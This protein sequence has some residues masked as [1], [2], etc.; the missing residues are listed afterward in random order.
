VSLY[1]A[2]DTATSIASVAVGDA[3][4]AVAEVYV[5]RRRHSAATVPAIEEVLE[6]A[7]RSFA[8]L[9]G[10]VVA[11]GPGSFTGLR[12]GFATALGVLEQY[13]DL[14]LQTAPSLLGVA[15]RAFPLA[16]GPVAAVFDALRG[17]VF[18]AVYALGEARVETLM[19]PRIARP[20]E[21]VECSPRPL[22]AVGDGAAAY[23]GLMQEWTGRP[24][25]GPPAVVPSASALLELL[26]VEGATRR[27]E[28]PA[29][30]EPWYG[31]PAEAQARWERTHGRPLPDPPG[32]PV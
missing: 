17:E 2:L 13:P 21:L 26:A 19:E 16:Q 7:G 20:A 12:I 30:L 9:T 18:A 25:V 22:L 31:R 29:A 3:A 10:I 6:L 4:G 8:D 27:V 32:H 28:D 24:P 23:A 1:L 11:D 15:W 14:V 5:G